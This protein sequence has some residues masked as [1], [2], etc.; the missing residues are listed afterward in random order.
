MAH[1]SAN[2]GGGTHF[3]NAKGTGVKNNGGTLF[4][5][6]TVAATS[7]ITVS[8][9]IT[10]LGFRSGVSEPKPILEGSENVGTS[11][12]YSAGN[13]ANMVA[14]QYI[15]FGYS[16]QVAGQANNAIAIG[17]SM[18]FK[19]SQNYALSYVRTSHYVLT[20]V[21][22]TQ[23]GWN[24]VTGQPI[25]VPVSISQDTV[26]SDAYKGTYLIPG[27]I[28]FLSTGKLITTQNYAAKTD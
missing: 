25:T 5:G 9:G 8:M 1:S 2:Y 16:K 12:P 24:Y 4:Y 19:I 22:G 20:A 21:N 28:S 11:K 27:R 23:S 15:L 14:G 7:P 3:V 18:G 6:G 17:G 26:N 10:S 13:F